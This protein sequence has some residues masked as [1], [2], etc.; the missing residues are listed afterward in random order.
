MIFYRISELMLA[1]LIQKYDKNDFSFDPVQERET[2]FYRL[3]GATFY[4]IRS[5]SSPQR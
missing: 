3:S 1:I 2:K 4:D 5:T